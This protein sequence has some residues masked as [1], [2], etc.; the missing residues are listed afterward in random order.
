C[1]VKIQEK[2]INMF[3]YTVIQREIEYLKKASGHQNL[4]AFR[5]YEEDELHTYLVMDLCSG[6]TLFTSVYFSHDFFENDALVKHVYGQI[7]DGVQYLHSNTIFHRDLKLE[8]ILVTYDWT[9][10][11]IDFGVA[12]DQSI[13]QGTCGTYSYAS[14]D[15]LD[16]DVIGLWN[17]AKADVWAL[18]IIL[19]EMIT[20]H[21]PWHSAVVTDIWYNRYISHR[22]RDSIYFSR[23]L[24]LSHDI[25]IALHHIFSPISWRRPP[26]SHIR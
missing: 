3:Y 20:C 8:N 17:S 18:G 1:A 26:I 25:A 13:S 15:V 11:I 21:R 2:P 4:I 16:A 10:K 22:D 14:P 19:I 12:T 5:S 24:P 7:L 9:V 23:I 6:N